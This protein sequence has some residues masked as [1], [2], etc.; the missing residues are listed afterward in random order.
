[1][2]VRRDDDRDQGQ[3]EEMEGEQNEEGRTGIV[4]E[5]KDPE[6]DASVEECQA[7]N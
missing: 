6:D 2:L 5:K 4:L 3:D 1:M 7:G